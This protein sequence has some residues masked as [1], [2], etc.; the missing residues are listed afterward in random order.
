MEI[1][2]FEKYGQE[3]LKNYYQKYV[4]DWHLDFEIEKQIKVCTTEGI[5]LNGRFD[6]I[7]FLN[8]EIHIIDY[9]TGNPKKAE[10]KLL[11]PNHKEPH[12]G[13]YWRQAAFYYLLFLEERK[14]SMTHL[15]FIF[16]FIEP[17]T[18]F[19]KDALIK[20]SIII[21]SAE[22]EEF[23]KIVVDV[24]QKI[25]QHDFKTGCGKPECYWCEFV[26]TNEL[27]Q[28]ILNENVEE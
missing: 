27:N 2:K 8:S 25:K 12:G 4:Q 6:K 5:H 20:K 14:H 16:D 15:Q 7:E 9:K 10:A 24:W 23:K 11:P 19:N 13:S 3:C 22:I 18:P 21:S 28:A 17:E 1:N 26:K